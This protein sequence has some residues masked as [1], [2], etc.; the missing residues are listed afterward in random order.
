MRVKIQTQ[1]TVN[2]PYS[3]IAAIKYG[4]ETRF[5]MLK[6]FVLLFARIAD[7]LKRIC[8]QEMPIAYTASIITI[9]QLIYIFPCFNLK[10]KYIIFADVNNRVKGSGIGLK[11]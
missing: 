11:L 10:M 4:S 6:P 1:K 9:F 5:K 7:T 2:D 8:P 3:A